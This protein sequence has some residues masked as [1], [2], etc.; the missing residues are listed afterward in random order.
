MPEIELKNYRV[1]EA[2]E[3]DELQRKVMELAKDGFTPHG[4][5]SI[6]SLGDD[7][8]LYAQAMSKEE[9]GT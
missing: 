4:G 3:P 2:G 6:V 5:V 7:N 9:Y 1:V 8:L